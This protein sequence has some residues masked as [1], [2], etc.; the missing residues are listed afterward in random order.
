MFWSRARLVNS[1]IARMC[2]ICSY[3][4]FLGY[5]E[6]RVKSVRII[7]RT[8]FNEGFGI[9]DLNELPFI[10]CEEIMLEPIGDEKEW[11]LLVQLSHKLTRLNARTGHTHTLPGSRL[12]IEGIHYTIRG[13]PLSLKLVVGG[14]RILFKPD[15]ISARGLPLKKVARSGILS[16]QQL[17]IAKAAF[18][19]GW[20]NVP[21][22]I[23]MSKLA[24]YLEMARSTLSEH[25]GRIETSLMHDLFGSFST[26]ILTEEQEAML[27]EH[28]FGGLDGSDEMQVEL[29]RVFAVGLAVELDAD[30]NIP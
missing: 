19:K 16:P 20:Y 14:A 23:S 5:I 30:I 29:D 24:I 3:A 8:I 21:R 9:D 12:D 26:S 28:A 18:D 1:D 4:E 2:E 10:Q 11:I 22:G 27:R 13:S 17:S 6:R 7:L 15:R 25:L